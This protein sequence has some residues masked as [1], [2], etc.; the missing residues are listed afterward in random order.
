MFFLDPAEY[1]KPFL[2]NL[3][4][5]H[6]EARGTAPDDF[7]AVAIATR[8]IG[9]DPVKYPALRDRTDELRTMLRGFGSEAGQITEVR[10]TGSELYKLFGFEAVGAQFSTTYDILWIN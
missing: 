8:Y 5:L 4:A 7:R 2:R 1:A 6:N 10:Y 3:V 9:S